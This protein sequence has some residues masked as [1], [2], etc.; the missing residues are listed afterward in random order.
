MQVPGQ[1]TVT[2][3]EIGAPSGPAGAFGQP[4]AGS[5]FQSPA[6]QFAPASPYGLRPSVPNYLVQAI[7]CTLFCCLPFGIVAI[8]YAAQV[9]GKL[10]VGD[11]RGATVASGSARTWCWVSFGLGFVPMLL[12]IL[13]MSASVAVHR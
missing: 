13:V 8:V 6:G 12:W 7:L 11:Y 1:Q 5:P 10:S 2:A 4:E 9:D 3:E